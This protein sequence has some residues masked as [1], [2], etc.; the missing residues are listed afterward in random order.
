MMRILHAAA[1]ATLL[2]GALPASAQNFICPT[3]PPGTS[4]NRCASTAF[5]QNAVGGGAS[6]ITIG[7]TVINGGAPNGLLFDS[8]GT[9][10]NLATGNSGVLITSGGGVPSISSTLPGALTIPSPTLAT[11]TINGA[12][13]QNVGTPVYNVYGSSLFAQNLIQVDA[14]ATEA[15]KGGWFF[16]IGATTNVPMAIILGANS[17]I[18]AYDAMLRSAT[19]SAADSVL[20]FGYPFMQNQGPGLVQGYGVQMWSDSASAGAVNGI[21]V[22]MSMRSASAAA[23]SSAIIVDNIFSN[24]DDVASIFLYEGTSTN[25]WLC[26]VCGLAATKFKNAVFDAWP[27]TGSTGNAYQIRNN[28]GAVLAFWDIAGN[29]N[30]PTIKATTFLQGGAVPVASLPTCNAGAKAARYFVIDADANTFHTTAAG[31]G[32]NN[33]AVVCDGTNWYID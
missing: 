25:R 2:L 27:A 21:N 17:Q 28:A 14:I 29:L 12:V 32:A 30:A 15:N 1:I 16:N 24:Q 8:A 5:V 33:V 10:G 19:T 23:S 11:P 20:S 6:G 3:A 18:I 4:D 31:G 7:M 22:Q 9:V 26:G 13:V